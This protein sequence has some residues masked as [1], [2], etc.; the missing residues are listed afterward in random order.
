MASAEE[1]ARVGCWL[2]SDAATYMTGSN[3]VVDGG[4]LIG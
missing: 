2:L 3:V 1:V 4:E